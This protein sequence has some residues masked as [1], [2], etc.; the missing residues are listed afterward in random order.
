MVRSPIL[1]PSREDRYLHKQRTVVGCE[2]DSYS[3]V[4][5]A[6]AAKAVNSIWG[7]KRAFLEEVAFAL[8]G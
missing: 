6:V 1:Q 5:G 8:E 7:V 4:L 3:G 2:R